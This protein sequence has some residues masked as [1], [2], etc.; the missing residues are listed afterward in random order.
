[1]RD[2]QLIMQ[3]LSVASDMP[4][5]YRLRRIYIPCTLPSSAIL[6]DHTYIR[7]RLLYLLTRPT[8]LHRRQFGTRD[9]ALFKRLVLSE[10]IKECVF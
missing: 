5:K 9:S 10:T 3:L 4:A 1:M 7:G 2:M 6:T 8:D